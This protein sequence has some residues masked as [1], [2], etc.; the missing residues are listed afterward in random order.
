MIWQRRR[1]TPTSKVKAFI[2][3]QRAGDIPKYNSGR[4]RDEVSNSLSKVQE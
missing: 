1:G 4:E 2:T 3:Y